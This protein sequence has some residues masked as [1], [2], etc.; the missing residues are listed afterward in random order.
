MI[1]L[2][3][4]TGLSVPS[5][6]ACSKIRL[7]GDKVALKV[8][9]CFVL[10]ITASEKVKKTDD[11]LTELPT[12]N[13]ESQKLTHLTANR[14]KLTNRTNKSRPTTMKSQLPGT[15]ESIDDGLDS[16]FVSKADTTVTVETPSSKNDK[17]EKK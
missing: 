17:V 8:V 5:L 12:L 11:I 13:V 10:F 2:H 14:P 4:H 1:R 6:F 16:F 7:S 9:A 3:I 15:S